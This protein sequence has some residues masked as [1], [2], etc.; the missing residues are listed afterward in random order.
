[1]YIQIS[2]FLNAF[3]LHIAIASLITCSFTF[4]MMIL[5]ETLVALLHLMSSCVNTIENMLHMLHA[6]YIRHD[7]YADF[8]LRLER[9]LREFFSQ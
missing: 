6:T 7:L 4:I 8:S 1:V 9:S 5:S 3:S 2:L